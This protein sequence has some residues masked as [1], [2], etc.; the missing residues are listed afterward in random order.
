MIK[1]ATQPPIFPPLFSEIFQKVKENA[2]IWKAINKIGMKELNQEV[3]E[4]LVQFS[5][6][7]IETIYIEFLEKSQAELLAYSSVL[8]IINQKILLRKKL[9]IQATCDHDLVTESFG[10]GQIC[11]KCGE[12]TFLGFNSS[13]YKKHKALHPLYI[14][15]KSHLFL[16]FFEEKYHK[17]K[18]N[19]MI[20]KAI[21]NYGE[22]R[23]LADTESLLSQFD[24]AEI[25]T[26]YGQFLI[27]NRNHLL[28]PIPILELIH[29]KIAAK[30]IQAIQ[31]KCDHNMVINSMM[32]DKK[33]TKCGL[34]EYSLAGSSGTISGEP[35]DFIQ[36]YQDNCN[37]NSAI[38]L[39]DDHNILP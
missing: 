21:N 16:S 24:E 34:T 12:E 38:T 7:E 15:E 22:K 8:N 29:E 26:I 32:G 4:L 20:W 39:T 35:Y 25:Q 27:R 18:E 28:N 10:A 33:C 37:L 3:E 36:H 1:P 13:E 17:I 6:H 2:M 14:P 11:S 19:A 5:T 31:A 30:K 9:A 23:L